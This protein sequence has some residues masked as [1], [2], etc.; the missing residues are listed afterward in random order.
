MEGGNFVDLVDYEDDYIISTE[1]PYEIRKKKTNKV[2]SE[3]IDDG[4]VVGNIDEL[5]S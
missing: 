2:V 1:Y 5:T 4:G 3:C